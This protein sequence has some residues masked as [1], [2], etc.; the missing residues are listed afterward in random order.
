MKYLVLLL[1]AVIVWLAWK[2][3]TSHPISQRRSERPEEAM[4]VC[5]HCQVHLPEGES[6]QADGLNYCCREHLAAGAAHSRR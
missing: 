1:L 4:V 2:K 6:L 3:R 5:A